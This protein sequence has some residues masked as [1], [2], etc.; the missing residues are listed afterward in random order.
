MF[1][2]NDSVQK[3]FISFIEL[4]HFKKNC[5]LYNPEKNYIG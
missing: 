4:L 2:K 5:S 3:I 1:I